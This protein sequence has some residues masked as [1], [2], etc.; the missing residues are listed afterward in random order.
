L[1]PNSNRHRGETS[2]TD[3]KNW[4]GGHGLPRSV[5][6]GR[7]IAHNTIWHSKVT[8]CGPNG[9]RWWSADAPAPRG[10]VK[11]KCGWA[12]LPHYRESARIRCESLR[13]KP[14]ASNLKRI[15][16]ALDRCHSDE[17]IYPCIDFKRVR[18]WL[19]SRA[20]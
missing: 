17:E 14:T 18:A 13:R 10:W 15:N 1:R 8:P 3:F 16:D 4:R 12:G 6:A 20:G 2:M 19:K 9:F 7:F 11:C 5:A